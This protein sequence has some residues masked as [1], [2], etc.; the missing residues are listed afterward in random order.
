MVQKYRR[1]AVPPGIPKLRA[2]SS[3]HPGGIPPR[4][5]PR[6]R[7]DGDT[8]LTTESVRTLEVGGDDAVRLNLRMADGVNAAGRFVI[9]VVDAFNAVPERNET[10]NLTISLPVS[11][12]GHG[13]RP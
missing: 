6:P 5:P 3:N 7:D 9:A 10:N 1:V 2:G 13:T 4:R 11:S 12:H 8:F